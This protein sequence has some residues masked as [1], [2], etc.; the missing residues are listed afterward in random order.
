MGSQHP[1]IRLDTRE[2]DVLTKYRGHAVRDSFLLQGP[3]YFILLFILWAYSI[4]GSL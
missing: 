2:H 4:L 3:L 1:C